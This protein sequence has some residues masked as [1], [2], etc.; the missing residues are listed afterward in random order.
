MKQFISFVFAALLVSSVFAQEKEKITDD[1]NNELKINLAYFVFEIVELNYERILME[2]FS[3]GLSANYWFDDQTNI[4]YMISPFFRFYPVDSRRRA[5][6]FFIEGNAAII[7]GRA[8]EY[9]YSPFGFGYNEEKDFVRGG[10]GVA[11][12]GKFLSKNHFVGEAYAG[13]GRIFGSNNYPE[14]YPRVGITFGKRF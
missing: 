4:D 2:E 11:V 13:I 7:G 5:A 12:G 9:F 1:G 8:Y 6:G 10:A 14:V 3:V